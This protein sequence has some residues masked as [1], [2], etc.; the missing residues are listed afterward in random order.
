ADSR[1]EMGQAAVAFN[2]VVASQR[3]LAEIAQVVARGDLTRN[4]SPR[5]DKDVL[6]LAFSQMVDN[7]R[8]LVGQVKTSAEGLADS[9]SQLGAA[10]GQ[11]GSAVQQVNQTI[12]NVA[13][14]AQGQAETVQDTNHSMVEL[15]EAIAQVAG[16][17]Q[18]QATTVRA[19][20]TTTDELLAGVE[21]VATDA[22]HVAE[23][24][25]QTREVA[26]RG[27]QMVK[28]SIAGIN[29]L[30]ET[31]DRSAAQIEALGGATEQIGVVVD[32]ID[33]IAEQTNLLA[34]NAAIEAA[35]AGEHGR[36]FAVVADE[37][38]KLAERSGKETRQIAEL[39]RNVQSSAKAAVEAMRAGA[40]EAED[41]TA[42][43]SR[44]GEALGQIVDSAEQTV[45]Q[46]ESI[47]G[48]A[49]SMAASSIS[50]TEAMQSITDA[51]AEAEAAADR[52]DALAR[53][54]TASVETIAATAEENSAATEEMS[55]SAEEMSA[56]VQEVVASAEALSTMAAKLREAV[57][58]F[59]LA[60]EGL[61]PDG[62]V[63]RRRKSDWT[64]APQAVAMR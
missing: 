33:D 37:V 50:M 35:R 17:A 40:K 13:A 59:S 38:R 28:E 19:A 11:T 30:K 64:I 25:Q 47:A 6:G 2:E 23:A 53:R 39:V 61:S 60:E 22:G 14:G 41:G 63:P 48:A 3:T 58:G 42:L 54:V 15:S 27:S 34:L 57:A 9:S 32:T 62:M 4:V 20:R 12:Q 21:R 24:S 45:H 36:G 31:V 26:V 8:G 10:A 7:L 16:G 56:Q 52:M 29:R 49:Q 5:S 44:A 51:V 46:V 1:D 43:A 55:A 18:R